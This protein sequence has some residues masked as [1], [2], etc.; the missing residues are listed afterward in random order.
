MACKLRWWLQY[1][2]KVRQIG[3]DKSYGADRKIF[4]GCHMFCIKHFVILSNS[5]RS[6]VV[7]LE[8]KQN[9]R[10]SYVASFHDGD[11][12]GDTIRP[13]LGTWI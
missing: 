4:V 7:V 1:P 6:F 9:R 2:Q 10:S 8:L 13:T 3:D 5:I 12:R 11:Q